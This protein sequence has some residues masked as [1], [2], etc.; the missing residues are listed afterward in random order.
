MFSEYLKVFST[1][2]KRSF[3]FFISATKPAQD[4]SLVIFPRNFLFWKTL[5]G[6]PVLIL[7]Q[8]LTRRLVMI[9]VS[10]P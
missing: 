1:P 10:S 9:L 7:F 4:I 3:L 8:S 6:T 5:C 2:K